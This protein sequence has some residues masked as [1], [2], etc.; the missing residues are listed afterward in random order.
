MIN[1]INKF[2]IQ[3]LMLGR[4]I[5]RRIDERRTNRRWSNQDYILEKIE[6]ADFSIIAKYANCPE[7][8]HQIGRYANMKAVIAEIERDNIPGDIVEFGTWQGLGIILLSRLFNSHGT[9]RKFVGID[10]FEG[11][12]ETSTIWREGQFNDTNYNFAY[13]NISKHKAS[14]WDF[15]L[16]K[17]WFDDP[18]VANQLYQAV[19]DVALVHF[20]ADLKSSTTQALK[21]IETYLKT[22]SHPIFFLFDDWGCHPDEVPDAFFEWLD[23]ACL[24]YN[25]YVTKISSTKYARYYKISR[26]FDES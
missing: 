12:P 26:H 13:E 20:D 19:N 7:V 6:L 2:I 25:I 5:L 18:L 15:S 1:I 8:E 11:L 17:G 4:Y 24:K 10:S 16:I 22:I 3:P 21:I 14:G 23:T 9:T